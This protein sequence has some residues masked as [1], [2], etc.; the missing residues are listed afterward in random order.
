MAALPSACGIHLTSFKSSE[1]AWCMP[2]TQVLIARGDHWIPIRGHSSPAVLGSC[3]G[4]NCFLDGPVSLHYGESIRNKYI[5]SYWI[6]WLIIEST[7]AEK[8]MGVDYQE[9]QWAVALSVIICWLRDAPV[10][11]SVS[12]EHRCAVC[13]HLRTLEIW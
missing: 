1:S 5:Y 4:I 7:D 3:A 13:P 2:V 12:M 9:S 11:Y 8:I 10:S 6:K